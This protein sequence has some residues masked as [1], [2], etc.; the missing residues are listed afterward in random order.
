MLNGN[1]AVSPPG[2]YEA[3]GTRVVYTRAA[4]PEETL[5]AAGPTSQDL[6]L[7]VRANLCRGQL[8]GEAGGQTS[9]WLGY[10]RG[11]EA[12]VGEG[13]LGHQVRAAPEV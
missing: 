5:S 3:A 1:W 9:G 11:R 13:K 8:G 7:Q 12:G 4:G 10:R 6:L 2:T